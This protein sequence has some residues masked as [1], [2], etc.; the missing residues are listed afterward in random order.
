M[1]DEYFLPSFPKDDRL[2]LKTVEVPQ[3]AGD[4]P[5]FNSS[6]WKEFM[7]LKAKFLWDELLAIPEGDIYGFLDVDIIT[8]NNFY[9]YVMR[10]MENVDFVAQSD[11]PT[12]M[13][14]NCCTGI[15]FFR[16]NDNCRNLLRATYEYLGKL[17]FK[18]EQEAFTYF[19]QNRTHFEE[20]RGLNYRL[21]PFEKAWTY[22]SI[23]G[24][25]WN[26]ND[27]DFKIPDK[28]ELL[29]LHANWCQ[30]ENKEN[31]LNLFRQKLS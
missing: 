22:G 14:L 6:K 21:F 25:I 23:A 2:V 19:V 15:L 7:F 26:N 10:Y 9:D 12:P 11:S 16:N 8:V 5:E 29:W 27:F 4:K 3:L 18:N 28:K 24:R 20:L 30:H 1:L 31:L 17:P 13:F